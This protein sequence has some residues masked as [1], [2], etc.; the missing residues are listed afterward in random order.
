VILGSRWKNK[1][2]GMCGNYNDI[3][4]DEFTDSDN[5]VYASNAR[6]WGNH[7]K[8]IDNCADA[9][10]DDDFDT[11]A[12][13]ELQANHL[14]TIIDVHLRQLSSRI[15]YQFCTLVIV[16]NEPQTSRTQAQVLN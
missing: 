16:S 14:K 6:D 1:V 3:E 9:G 8:T 12:V 11:C 15:Q 10:V 7:W 5:G 13:G 2:E 4:E